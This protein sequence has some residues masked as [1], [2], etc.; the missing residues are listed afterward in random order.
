MNPKSTKRILKGSDE[1]RSR[2]R[3]EVTE[4]AEV[5][6]STASAQ[7]VD[8]DATL[9]SSHV[10]VVVKV[11]DWHDRKGEYRCIVLVAYVNDRNQTHKYLVAVFDAVPEPEYHVPGA[12]NSPL[13]DRWNELNTIFEKAK[14][15]EIEVICESIFQKLDPRLKQ[16]VFNTPQG[17]RVDQN[18]GL[19]LSLEPVDSSAA[20]CRRNS[21]SSHSK[22]SRHRTQD[23]SPGQTDDLGSIPNSS[24]QPRQSTG[25]DI[26]SVGFQWGDPNFNAAPSTQTFG[27]THDE[28]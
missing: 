15:Q 23:S 20:T 24:F 28:I 16:L 1:T 9:A 26:R 5:K 21:L 18:T 4:D 6:A 8:Q 10:Q 13:L 22:N 14:E 27:S 7:S 25:I 2:K 11:R 3:Q 12:K 17:R 19:L